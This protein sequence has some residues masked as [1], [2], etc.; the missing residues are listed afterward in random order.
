[1]G[2]RIALHI[3]DVDGLGIC[4][5]EESVL[6]FIPETADNGPLDTV[7]RFPAFLGLFLP[8]EVFCDDDS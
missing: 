2:C 3:R 5:G 8:L 4:K 6:S 1:M 7:G